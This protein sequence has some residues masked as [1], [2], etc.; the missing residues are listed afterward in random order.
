L[1]VLEVEPDAYDAFE[2][3]ARIQRAAGRWSDLR[4]LLERRVHVARDRAVRLA[5]L[6]ELAMLEEDVLGRPEQAIAWHRQVIEADAGQLASYRALDRLLAAAERWESLEELLARAADAV[7]PK[8]RVQLAYR[9]AELFAHRLGEP[10]RAVDLL[11]EVLGRQRGHAD[12][13]E[14]L[15]ELLARPEAPGVPEV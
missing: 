15:E 3:L 2:A 10:M 13:R 14:L 5:A 9:R 6:Q 4:G 1:V 8:E 12:A 11:E 7:E